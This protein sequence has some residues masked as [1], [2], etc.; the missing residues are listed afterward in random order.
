MKIDL[1]SLG[2]NFCTIRK[3]LN[4]LLHDYFQEKKTNIFPL[5]K[6]MIGLKKVPSSNALVYLF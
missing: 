2:S 4:I 6:P 3:Y 5:T 1:H